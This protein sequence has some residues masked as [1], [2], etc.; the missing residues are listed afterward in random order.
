V[1]THGNPHEP[2]GAVALHHLLLE[3]RELDVSVAFF[4]EVLG[5]TIRKEE[6]FRDGRRLVVTHQGLG[7]TEGGDPGGRVLDHL[8]FEARG[9]DHL[10]ERARSAGH[11]VVRG[12]GPGPYGHTV[13]IADPDGNEIELFEHPE[14]SS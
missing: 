3:A 4:V 10:A 11:Q 6:P 9:V 5:F 8:C 12:P 14:E 1:N 2:P 7:L 13:Y